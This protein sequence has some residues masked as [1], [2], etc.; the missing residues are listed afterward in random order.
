[1]KPEAPV[2]DDRFERKRVFDP[3]V[4]PLEAWNLELD[5]EASWRKLGARAAGE[6][7]EEGRGEAEVGARMAARAAE[8]AAGIHAGRYPSARSAEAFGSL[9]LAGGLTEIPGFEETAHSL[10][11]PFAVRI[12]PGGRFGPLAGARGVLARAGRRAVDA[13]AVDVGQTG[14]KLAVLGRAAG[15]P[16]Y[17]E[18][19][20]GVI[21]LVPTEEAR[22][23]SAPDAER[24]AAAAARWIGETVARAA[25]PGGDAVVLALP[26]ELDAELRPGRCTYA[27]WKGRVGLAA[28]ITRAAG[29]EARRAGPGHPWAS[30][31]RVDWLLLND[32]ELAGFAAL[33]E[34]ARLGRTGAA[35]VMTLG[36]GPGCAFLPALHFRARGSSMVEGKTPP[37]E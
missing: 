14:I 1:L 32:A 8:L 23:V 31:G 18:R 35:L 13:L 4:R 24:L 11:V 21:P 2:P 16:Q 12:L 22:G 20:A 37:R 29:A 6:L 19:P 27:G 17:V 25:P 26:C 33:D 28:E 7:R 3:R 10:D 9:F 5:G 34:R 15:P 30:G 36:L